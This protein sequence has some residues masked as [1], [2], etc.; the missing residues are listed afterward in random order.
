[1]SCGA[2]GGVEPMTAICCKGFSVTGVPA[3]R[4]VAGSTSATSTTPVSSVKRDVTPPAVPAV[5]SATTTVPRT[6][7]IAFGV[8]I[9]MRSPR[10]MRSLLTDSAS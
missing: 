2:P 1:M 10:F 5:T 4:P 8:L 7:V 6:A 9:S 3:G